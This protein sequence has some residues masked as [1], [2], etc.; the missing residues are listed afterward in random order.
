MWATEHLEPSNSLSQN[1]TPAQR[2]LRCIAIRTH[3]YIHITEIV[4]FD[5]LISSQIHTCS[6]ILR[7]VE[8]AKSLHL[9][10]ISTPSYFMLLLIRRLETAHWQGESRS[11]SGKKFIRLWIRTW[12]PLVIK[13]GNGK[14]NVPVNGLEVSMGKSSI[15]G[16]FSIAMF[17][18]Q[19][20]ITC[21]DPSPCNSG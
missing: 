13:H 17:D 12:Y 11:S 2:S 14:S 10:A 19:T 16:G 5:P 20:V 15:D 9:L 8:T 18:Y 1:G 4:T 7:H 21:V 6:R 3:V